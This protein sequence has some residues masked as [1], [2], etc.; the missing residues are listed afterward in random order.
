[1]DSEFLD[2]I[3]R[4]KQQIKWEEEAQNNESSEEE[5]TAMIVT[6]YNARSRQEVK[7]R[8]ILGREIN[9]RKPKAKLL[10]KC[11]LYV[12]ECDLN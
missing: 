4:V 6:N 12:M 11:K 1:M 7:Q 5:N 8:K 2:E 10:A 9:C 3:A